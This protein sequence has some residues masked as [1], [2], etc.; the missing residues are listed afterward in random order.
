MKTK[1]FTLFWLTGEAQTVTG[2]TIAEAMNNAGIGNGALKA[3]DFYAEGDQTEKYNWEKEQRNW[4]KQIQ[5]ENLN[6]CADTALN[7]KK[8]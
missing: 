7:S 8:A 3:L 1:T 6:K 5:E 2:N 4:I